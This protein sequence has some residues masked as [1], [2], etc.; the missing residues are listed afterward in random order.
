MPVLK[1]FWKTVE[2]QDKKRMNS[3][4]P[5]AGI[6]E[7]FDIPYI[8]DGTE[9]H[10]LDVY[11]KEDISEKQPVIIDIH[12]GGWMY[13]TKKINE[14]YNLVLAS[15]GYTVVSINY[16]LVPE[17]DIGDQ[18]RDCFYAF[19][20]VFENIENYFGDLNNVFLT[21]DSAGGFL[22]ANTAVINTSEELRKIYSVVPEK[23]DFKAV[24]LTSPVCYLECKDIT[25]IYY[26]EILGKNYKSSS[27]Y[28]LVNLDKIIDKG[29]MPPAF[30]VTSTGDIPAKK[31]TKQAFEL[32]KSKDIK[33]EY[34]FW[35]KTD[36]K[37]LPHVFSVVD[38]YSEPAIKTINKM[39]GFF[40]QFKTETVTY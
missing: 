27:Y 18:I 39:L 21:G 6:K 19:K 10:K 2:A 15:K 22:A 14:Y 36:G 11:Y 37:D 16:R 34:M 38:P 25:K 35:Q 8:N 9:F 20:W 3:Q 12:G 31:S 32:L 17:A 30:L 5:T 33:S 26:N 28:G 7:I 23:L 40:K 13:G 29:T 1:K 24:G 4:M